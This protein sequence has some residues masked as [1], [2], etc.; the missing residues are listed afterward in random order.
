MVL[1]AKVNL[2][3]S[4]IDMNVVVFEDSLDCLFS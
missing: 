4:I 2:L 3:P 1:A